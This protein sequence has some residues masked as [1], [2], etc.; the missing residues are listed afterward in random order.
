[1]VLARF[2]VRHSA[3]DLELRRPPCAWSRI[4]LKGRGKGSAG[5]AEGLQARPQQATEAAKASLQAAAAVASQGAEGT[6]LA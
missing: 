6:G 5:L 2:S 4:F 3:K 1:M